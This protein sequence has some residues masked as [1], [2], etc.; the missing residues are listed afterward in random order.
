MGISTSTGTLTAGQSR[1]FN[2][3]PASAVTLTLSPNVRVTITETPATV[4]A[5]GLGG[6]ASRVHEP[7]LPGVVTYGPYPMGGSVL[8]EVES[9]SG[10]SVAW[11]RS[12]SII[13]ESA[14][15]AQSLVSGDG[16][17]RSLQYGGAGNTMLLFGDSFM[18]RHSNSPL[19]YWSDL[20]YWVWEAAKLGGRLQIIRNSGVSGETTAA[21][22]ARF[23]TDVTPY[24]SRFV[25]INGG[26]NDLSTLTGAQTVANMRLMC[27]MILA[28]GR[29]P[30]L[31]TPGPYTNNNYAPFQVLMAYIVDGYYKIAS[32]LDIPL[33]DM[34]A[35]L[36][37]PTDANGNM[38][39]AYSSDSPSLHPN[40]VG[41]RRIQ[42]LA[43]DPVILPLLAGQAGTVVSA[44]NTVAKLGAAATQLLA[45][46]LLNTAGGTVSGT[47]QS[48]TAPSGWTCTVLSGVATGVWSRPAR[49]D[50]LGNDISCVVSAVTGASSLYAYTASQHTLVAEGDEIWGEYFF[51]QTTVVGMTRVSLSVEITDG[52]GA[53]FVRALDTYG[54]GYDVTD[55]P[56]GYKFVTPKTTIVG[57]PTNLRLVATFYFANGG[58][59]TFAIGVPVIRRTPV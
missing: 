54:A 13:A 40:V 26:V 9:N 3:A 1:T 56:A 52:L 28:L 19:T 43:C 45:N 14:D 12:D 22:L 51:S 25:A 53:R 5:T 20:G 2:L 7:R 24:P 23:A 30:L 17:V 8:V 6:N 55:I 35:A 41:A 47:G 18:A 57:T 50:G 46:P 49:A 48:G 44:A 38:T 21:M 27:Q 59:G 33:V 31:H 29:I 4:A 42:T 34:Y 36:I 39:A 37:N 58:S 16:N 10:S 15:G 11:V 32:D